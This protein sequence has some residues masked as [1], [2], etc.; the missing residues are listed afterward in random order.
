MTTTCLRTE[1]LRESPTPLLTGT[2]KAPPDEDPPVR[3][4]VIGVF[5]GTRRIRWPVLG[6]L[7]A[8]LAFTA[9]FHWTAI[10][11]AITRLFYDPQGHRWPWFYSSVCTWFY[12]GGIYP[13][14]LLAAA[15][16]VWILWSLVRR[17]PW[18]TVQGGVFLVVL[19]GIGP[20]LIVN[21][22]FKHSW[23]R[24]RPN[25][26]VEFGGSHEFVPVGLPGTLHQHNSSFPSGHAA[27]AF[28]MMAPAFLVSDRHRRLARSLMLGGVAFGGCMGAVRVIQG[29]H[30][31]SD[32]VW[33]GA[34]V[35]FTGLVLARLLLRAPSVIVDAANGPRAPSLGFHRAA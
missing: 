20:G 3:W 6:P 18:R 9:V 24:P 28:Y 33:S 15:G 34:I 32:V 16:I 7:M 25:Q 19:F 2:V 13:G 14:F 35:Y 23:G 30:F 17:S 11:I 27:V 1:P 21:Q 8:M 4:S 5:D 22:A 31:A 29:G 26:I 10:D 12:R